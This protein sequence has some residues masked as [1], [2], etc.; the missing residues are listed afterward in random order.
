MA[1]FS[2]ITVAR[3]WS[4][5]DVR[6]SESDCWPWTASINRGGYGKFKEGGAV[7]NASRIAWEIANDA[8][9]GGLVIRHHCDNPICCNPAHLTT[10]TPAQNVADM[11]D[12]GRNR[13]GTMR[14]ADNPQAKLSVDQVSKIRARILRGHSNTLIAQDFP[15]T[16]ATISLI[17]TG[18]SWSSHAE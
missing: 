14:G 6:K 10:G 13:S 8:R 18:K 12:R 15:V 4:K 2:P 9:A 17:R 16:D 3:F 11:M 1:V 5:V 7:Q